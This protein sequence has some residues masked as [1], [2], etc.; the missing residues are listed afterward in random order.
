[1]SNT[2]PIKLIMILKN[3]CPIFQW[4]DIKGVPLFDQISTT[5]SGFFSAFISLIPYLEKAGLISEGD[6]LEHI[7]FDKTRIFYRDND[8]F[9]SIYF[10][11]PVGPR[12]QKMIFQLMA[13]I[14][15]QFDNLYGSQL[16]EWDF[17]IEPFNE[18]TKVCDKTLE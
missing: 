16:R 10:I 11:S 2:S 15:K 4:G 14:D 13:K 1:M 18:F 17:N 8:L 9:Q 6:R 7:K 5:I 12:N 3:N